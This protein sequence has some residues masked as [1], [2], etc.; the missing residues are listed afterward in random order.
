MD[1]DIAQSSSIF[2]HK[3]RIRSLC[4]ILYY[5]KIIFTETLIYAIS[6]DRLHTYYHLNNSPLEK[7]GWFRR[8]KELHLLHHKKTHHKT[9][10]PFDI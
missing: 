3:L 8:K 4:T 7:Y 9:L 5:F 2:A 6:I 1:A 10:H